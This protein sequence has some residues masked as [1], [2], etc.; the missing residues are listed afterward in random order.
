MGEQSS[1]MEAVDAAQGVEGAQLA[2]QR[3]YL[4]RFALL[5][6]RDE[7]RAEDVVQETLLAAMQNR[8]GFSG[9]AQLRTWLTGILKHKIIDVFRRQAREAT[10]DPLAGEDDEA[11]EAYFDAARRDHWV[12]F[13][14]TWAD[15]EKSFEQKRFWEVFD[16]C[17]GQLSAQAARVFAMRELMGLETGEICKELGITANN[18]W[19]LLYRARMGLRQ[20]LEAKWFGRST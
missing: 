7:A 6:L 16:Q 14:Q 1:R 11:G 13:P 5:H 20:C 15:P 10:F 9:R 3:D 12:S 4:Y 18:C 2:A 19:V 17:S 8:E